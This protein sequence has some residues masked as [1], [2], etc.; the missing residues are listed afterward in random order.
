M[1]NSITADNTGDDCFAPIIDGGNNFADDSS[2][3]SG[4]TSI[5]PG[6]DFDSL[7]ADNGGPTQTHA[8]FP[9][10][11]AIDAAGN[12]GLATDQRGRLRN[13]GAC[14]SGPYEFRCEISVALR[15]RGF[16]ESGGC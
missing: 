3:G 14:D 10:S 1:T 6:E 16:N 7:L 4:F 13:D 12:C 5:T 2:C 8:L 15:G 9:D 11:A